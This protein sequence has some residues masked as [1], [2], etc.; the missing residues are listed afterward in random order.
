MGNEAEALAAAEQ[1]PAGEPAGEPIEQTAEEIFEA[2]FAGDEVELP[3]EVEDEDEDLGLG[4]GPDL[5][6]E[7]EATPAVDTPAVVDQKLGDR[8]RKLEGKFGGMNS[9]MQ[10]MKSSEKS[11]DRQGIDRPDSKTIAAAMN[12]EESY[13][14]MAEEFPEYTALLDAQNVHIDARYSELD[15]KLT[16]NDEEM[17]ALRES[18]AEMRVELAHP[19][20]QDTAKTDEF[21]SWLNAQDEETV[22]LAAASN[23]A[24]AITLFDKYAESRGDPA[25][26]KGSE[27]PDEINPR[28]RGAAAPTNGGGRAQKVTG[29]SRQSS[30]E[31][32]FSGN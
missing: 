11:A 5:E 19:K 29:P 24:A 2:S 28:L 30:F 21:K 26:G 31:S 14:A 23:P 10:R 27:N 16:K 13:K 20:W 32:G 6:L 25:A 1:A 12:D 7:P 17:Q 15:S 22:A 8:L 4:V 9:E 3:P 18:N